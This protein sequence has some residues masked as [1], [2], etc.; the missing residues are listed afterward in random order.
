M[1]ENGQTIIAVCAMSRSDTRAR[2]RYSSMLCELRRAA[3]TVALAI[4]GYNGV[5][6]TTLFNIIIGWPLRPRSGEGGH[7]RKPRASMQDVFQ[8]PTDESNLA[9]TMTVNIPCHAYGPENSGR[10]ST[11]TSGKQLDCDVDG[12]ASAR[13]SR[14]CQAV[15]ANAPG[16]S[17]ACCSSH[18]SSCLTSRPIRLARSPRPRDRPDGAA[19]RFRTHDPEYHARS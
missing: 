10:P 1:P 4:P 19:E 2:R 15:C 3:R 12:R 11:S 7:Q 17:P 18:T 5:G 6:K 14:S 13:R 8:K 16:L 9:A